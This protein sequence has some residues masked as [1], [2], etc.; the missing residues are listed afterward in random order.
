MNYGK[1]VRIVVTHTNADK[2]DLACR[3]PLAGVGLAIRRM[4][5]HVLHQ[6]RD[7]PSTHRPSFALE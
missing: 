1:K 3:M 6:G 5:A 7:M 4:D 2:I